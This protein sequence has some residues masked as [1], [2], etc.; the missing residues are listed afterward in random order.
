[1]IFRNPAFLWALALGAIPIIIYLLMRYR[2]LR[3]FWGANY[4]LERALERLKKK[5]YWDQILLIVLR[6]LAVLA[7]VAAFAR[8]VSRAA[9]GTVSGTGIHHVLIVDASYSMA[10]GES[11][12]RRWD[13]GM[14][15]LKRL[16]A[17][18]GRGEVWSLYVIDRQPDWRADAAVVTTPD[19]TVAVLDTL[20]P[21]ET[22]AS[23]AKAFEAVK[24]KLGSALAEEK[25]EI[26][27]LADDQA[28]S[29]AGMEKIAFAPH[30]TPPIIW[31]NP[32]IARRENLA[33]TS[34]R[35]ASRRVLVDHP[36]RVFVTLRNFG[37]GPAADV[38]VDLLMNDRAEDNRFVSL[39]PAQQTTVH[40]DV[41][42]REAGSH[43]LTARLE[44]DALEYDNALTAGIEVAERFRLL[45]LRDPSR[46][47]P[48]DS[49]WRFLEVLGRVQ[50]M[51]QF[52]EPVFTRGPVAMSVTGRPDP[53]AL[54]AADAVL[55]DGGMPVGQALADALRRYVARGGGLILSADQ[56]VRP[57]RWNAV[58]GAAGLLPAPLVQL[59][60]ETGGGDKYRYLAVNQFAPGALRAFATAEAGDV[61][62]AKVYTWWQVGPR[63]E[64]TTVLAAY[65][66]GEPFAFRRAVGEGR[67]VMLTAGLNGW[68]NNLI[69]REFYVPLVFRLVSE[70]SAA[71][72]FARTLGLEEPIRL[73]VG[74]QVETVSFLDPRAQPVGVPAADTP[75]GRVATAPGG[76]ASGRYAMLVLASRTRRQVHFGVQGPR[77]DS[78]LAPLP[79]GRRRRVTDRLDLVE[80]PDWEQL[81][82][83][84]RQR[85][86]GGE[87]HHWLLLAAL[88]LLAGEKLLERRFV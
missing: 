78:D 74:P 20:R 1:M 59:R 65:D 63:A 72:I 56:N 79:D 11:D 81:Q 48:F 17:T 36:C 55:L 73:R 83:I 50:E 35:P 41:I 58:L 14:E 47:G 2:S 57:A 62:K 27:L 9:T 25:V 24:A 61:R 33:V 86:G 68:W 13:R 31:L 44:A 80:A 88:G 85:R 4:V 3:V 75:V 71:G 16:A 34:V 26:A 70:A 23:L 32:P 40:F 77:V 19:D 46:T 82:E 66:D 5:R 15:A 87:W 18:W 54:A 84:L 45:V 39:L 52:D 10:A 8:P 42:F 37:P 7:M 64:R 43:Y 38:R 60:S 49:A 69:V 22:C 6:V 21:A 28:L 51:E 53:A 76:Q 30:P 12:R 29:W 67:V